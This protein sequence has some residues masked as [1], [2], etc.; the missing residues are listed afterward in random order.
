MMSV[1][2][3][4]APYRAGR[5]VQYER[6]VIEGMGDEAAL[7]SVRSALQFIAGVKAV[8]ISLEDGVAEVDFDPTKVK[9]AQLHTAVRAV[10]FKSA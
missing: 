1:Q 9:P 8:R 6:L 7:R 2:A 10:G 5:S 3:T 4:A